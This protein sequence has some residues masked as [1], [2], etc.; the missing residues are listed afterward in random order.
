MVAIKSHIWIPG[1]QDA[2]TPRYQN[3]RI[4]RCLGGSSEAK[5]I[6]DNLIPVYQD[7]KID[8]C[9][10]EATE[11]LPIFQECLSKFP[12]P[13][14]AYM[15]LLLLGNIASISRKSGYHNNKMSG[16]L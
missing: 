3:A 9:S 5:Q 12:D 14:H 15:S 4:P 10:S 8:D 1:C 16:R 11:F 2:R 6:A 13:H 7:T